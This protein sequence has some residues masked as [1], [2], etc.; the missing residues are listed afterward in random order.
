[1]RR[2]AYPL[3]AHDCK[4][5]QAEPSTSQLGGP[6]ATP[7]LHS[8]SRGSRTGQPLSGQPS[9]RSRGLGTRPARGWNREPP[10]A[11]QR[12][13]L[14]K[15][16]QIPPRAGTSQPDCVPRG[17]VRW[18][19][20]RHLLAALGSRAGG[21]RWAREP[22]LRCRGGDGAGR[23]PPQSCRSA[24]PRPPGPRRPEPPLARAPAQQAR[25]GPR[26]TAEP[27]GPTGTIARPPPRG[28]P[29]PARRR[30][31]PGRGAG[32][33]RPEAPPAFPAP[34]RT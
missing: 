26:M 24:C 19:A 6:A 15:F 34:L 21:G 8:V 3:G 5:S 9:S 16:P 14:S 18:P 11:G 4:R 1:M 28:S 12:P 20:H 7:P 17:R 33:G 13:A 25:V 22:Q 27:A 32:P 10:P 31:P 2:T 30:F 29:A 23:A